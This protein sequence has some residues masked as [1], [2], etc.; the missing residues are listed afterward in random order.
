MVKSCLVERRS[1]R[2]NIMLMLIS[3]ATWLTTLINWGRSL[4]H[5]FLSRAASIRNLLNVALQ[6]ASRI[7]EGQKAMGLVYRQYGSLEPELFYTREGDRISM[8][9]LIKISMQVSETFITGQSTGNIS[10]N[11]LFQV[12]VSLQSRPLVKTAYHARL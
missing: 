4:P 3:S 2:G 6:A 8:L 5:L 1:P 10:T 11:I 12:F 7:S 9:L